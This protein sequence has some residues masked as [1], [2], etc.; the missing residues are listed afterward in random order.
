[1]LPS[2]EELALVE[3]IRNIYPGQDGDALVAYLGNSSVTGVKSTNPHVQVILD[4]LDAVRRPRIDSARRAIASS[5]SKGPKST[6]VTIALVDSIG[7]ATATAVVLRR[8]SQQPRD[9]IL[10]TAASAS[11]GTLG[12]ALHALVRQRALDGDSAKGDV[13]IVVHGAYVPSSWTDARLDMTRVLLSELQHRPMTPVAGVG[14]AR[15]LQIGL[16]AQ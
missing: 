3:Q 4:R 6:P 9:V 10:L 8:V 14:P 7:D 1:M 12:A 13:K 16:S 5:R 11:P 2:R 15:T